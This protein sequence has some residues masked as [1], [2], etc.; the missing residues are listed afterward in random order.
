VASEGGREEGKE[1]R[2]VREKCKRR[3]RR[4]AVATYM[5]VTAV[6]SLCPCTSF[7]PIYFCI[8]S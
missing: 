1:K 6:A 2:R 8:F 4:S 7:F 3:R 5:K